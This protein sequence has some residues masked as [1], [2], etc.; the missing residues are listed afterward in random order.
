ML[1]LSCL[2]DIHKWVATAAAVVGVI[3]AIVSVLQ[4]RKNSKQTR[5]RW[6]F[7]LHQRIYSDLALGELQIRIEE[8][9]TEFVRKEEGNTLLARLD[10]YLN[11]F[12]FIAYLKDKKQLRVDEIQAMFAFPLESIRKN[13]DV[14]N[15]IEKY[16]YE[17]LRELLKELGYPR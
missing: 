13:E 1:S 3:A 9:D 16:H 4:Y 12:E 7:D 2:F 6:L 17:Y 10:S 5:I 15:Y 11:F 8:A 14:H